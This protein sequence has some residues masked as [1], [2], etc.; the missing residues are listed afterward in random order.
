MLEATAVAFTILRKYAQEPRNKMVVDPAP[1]PT[2]LIIYI[3]RLGL[4]VM[5]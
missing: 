2:P 3:R 1:P 5:G 4:S